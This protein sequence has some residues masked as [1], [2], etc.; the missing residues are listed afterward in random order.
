MAER[1]P[2]AEREPPDEQPTDAPRYL[3]AMRRS[4]PLMLVIVVSAT[5]IVL[6]LSIALPKTYEATARIV[7]DDSTVSLPS[8]DVESV[9]RRLATVQAL[10]T[11]R[12]VLARSAR[13]L[14]GATPESLKG[15]V[16]SSVDRDANIIDI[17]ADDGDPRGAAAIANGVAAAFLDMQR[18]EE[19]TAIDRARNQLVRALDRL[20]SSSASA[21][22]IRAI[23]DRLS[24][25]SVSKATIGTDLR[26][27]QA[28]R[29]PDQAASPRPLRNTVF[30]FFAAIFV[31]ILAALGL[32]QIAPRLMGAQHLSRLTGLPILAAIPRTRHARSRAAPPDKHFGVVE[33]TLDARLTAA[34]NVALLTSPHGHDDSSLTAVLLA[35]ALAGTAGDTLLIAAHATSRAHDLVGTTEGPGF[36]DILDVIDST[37][38]AAA[39]PRPRGRATRAWNGSP[40]DEMLRDALKTV[41]VRGP[42]RRLD[43]L[44]HGQM[45]GSGSIGSACGILLEQ[46]RRADYR[47]VLIDGPPLLETIDGQLVARYADA[48]VLIC[49]VD[50]T[51]PAAAAEIR[52]LVERMAVPVLGLVSVGATDATPQLVIEPAPRVQEL[53]SRA[54]ADS[55]G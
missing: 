8:G 6:G 29:A 17:T 42:N 11:T 34:R 18:A 35:R 30:A 46:L 40:A 13:N 31:A 5:I 39:S 21:A 33:A 22:E 23:R 24:E 32:E 15:H 12:D 43:V 41:D 1:Q 9:K 3:A 7:L 14:P 20:R 28:A 16:H 50:R 36:R 51:S 47:F 19:A 48:V 49:R 53:R 4:W 2:W 10:L 44:P 27:A 45:T 38:P 26:L 54:R 37:A 55:A 25:L 52:Q